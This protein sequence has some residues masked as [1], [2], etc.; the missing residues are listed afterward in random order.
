M[1]KP[2]VGF[3]WCASC[4][5]CEEAIVDL[6]E[7]LLVVA[8]KID[9]VFWP[10]AMD[11]KYQDVRDMSENEIDITF[12]NGAIRTEEQEEMANLLRE[13]SKI[14]ISFGACSQ[15]GGIP[16][17]ANFHDRD[18]IFQSSYGSTCPSVD[19]PDFIVPQTKTD[20]PEGELTL[21]AFHN[22]VKSTD[23]VVEVDYYLP[24][25]SPAPYLTLN[26]IN[27]LLAG[28]R[29]EKGTVLAPVKALCDT[30]DRKDSKPDKI[31]L[32]DIK[33]VS[34]V[35]LDP[36]ECLLAQGI[37]CM[38]P[39][40]RSG[41]TQGGE[42]RCIKAN[43][44]CRGCYGPIPE[45]Q[46]VGASMISAIASIIGIEGEEN[47]SDEHVEKIMDTVVDPAGTFYRFSLATSY[48]RRK[49]NDYAKDN[50]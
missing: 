46:D 27:T 14:L 28:K 32:K 40:T 33:R 2:K 3:Y 21:P 22:T 34:E 37:I 47:M 45:V 11:F 42:G 5:G 7:D 10:C 13:K 25:C 36:E 44:P 16:G 31:M 30:C 48:L 17:L 38:G 35:E 43:M 4:G 41:C 29:P 9:I 50:N 12:I 8:E 49:L 23:Q 18:S 19:N 26:A 24:G 15:I 20:V 39:I 1:A 6:H